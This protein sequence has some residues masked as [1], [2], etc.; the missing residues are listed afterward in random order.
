MLFVTAELISRAIL[1][2]YK[3]ERL[4]DVMSNLDCGMFDGG[5]LVGANAIILTLGYGELAR[6]VNDEPD[7][8]T[9]HYGVKID[10]A[11]YDFDGFC[12][13]TEDWISRFVRNENISSKNL[14]IETGFDSKSEI[15]NDQIAIIEISKIITDQI[16][17]LAASENR[18]L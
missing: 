9:E 18:I 7:K 2:T 6:V 12:A 16:S 4:W 14:S 1:N 8:R 3:D 17:I 10:S 5:C 15:I 13:T 11:Y